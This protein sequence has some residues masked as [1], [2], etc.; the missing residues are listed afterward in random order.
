M[1]PSLERTNWEGGEAW[2]VHNINKLL[3]G[4]SND[5]SHEGCQQNEVHNMKE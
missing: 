3:Q 5:T 4:F 2:E 1:P